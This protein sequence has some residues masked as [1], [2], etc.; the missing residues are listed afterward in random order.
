MSGMS[1]SNDKVEIFI[2][3]G[4]PV[5]LTAAVELRRRGYT[6]RIID[7]DPIVSPESRALAV[8]AR[9]LELL[10]PSGVTDMLI[11]AGQK[12]KKMV[13]RRNQKIIVTIDLTKISHRFNFLLSLPQSKIEKILQDKL[14]EMGI[15]LE[16]NLSLQ[17]F[18]SG[19]RIGLNLSDG[20]KAETDKLIGAD[21]AHSLVRHKLELGFD[22]ESDQQKFGLC[23]VYLEDW[24]FSFDTIVLT[25]L[26]THLA[27]FIPMSEGYGRFISTIGDSPNNL[28]PDAKVKKID[29]ETD[30]KISYRQAS[31]YQKDNIFLAGDAAHIH[32]P[33][34]G[35]GMNLGIEDACWLAWLIEQGRA[36]EY[37]NLRHPVGAQVLKF[38][39][40]FTSFA[41]NRG[42]LQDILIRGLAPLIPLLPPVQSRIFRTLT[43]LDTPVAPWL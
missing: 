34:G 32:S 19:P 14:A 36:A 43:A 3:G 24:P 15:T 17:D 42:L 23:D 38:T 16:R 4:G 30:F 2:S 29:W 9:T 22:G 21:G 37:T 10:E 8:N 31:T 11:A 12:I 26:D 33:V 39:Q 18:R 6:P 1:K 25:I 7:P 40:S 35:R 5:G 27:P 20:S 28:P 13:I 41:K